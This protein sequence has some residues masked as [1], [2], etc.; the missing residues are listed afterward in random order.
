MGTELVEVLM[1]H[2]SKLKAQ[3]LNKIKFNYKGGRYINE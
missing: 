1:A 2:G 3:K